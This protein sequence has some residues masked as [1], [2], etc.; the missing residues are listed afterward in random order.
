MCVDGSILF[1]VLCQRDLLVSVCQIQ[2]GEEFPTRVRSEDVFDSREWV[3][4]NLGDSVD[5]QL[6]VV[7]DPMFPSR[8]TKGKIG[9][10]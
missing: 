9:A 10:T 5:G 7:T 3:C 6:V 8:L 4:V 1:R 2:L